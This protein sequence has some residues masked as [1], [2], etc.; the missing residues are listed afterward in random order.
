MSRLAQA[1][2]IVGCICVV[3]VAAMVQHLV[4]LETGIQPRRLIVPL[5]VGASFGILIVALVK[6]RAAQ[7]QSLA[8]LAAQRAEIAALNLR[9]S[10]TVRSQG[11]E[12]KTAERRLIEA[13]RLGAV[14]LLAGGVAHD[15]NNL[16]TV[17]LSGAAFLGE[18]AEG[19]EKEVVE[20]MLSAGERGATLTTQLL[21]LARPPRQSS[22]VRCLNRS[23]EELESL[24]RRLLG[25][26]IRLEVNRCAG[27]L[28][29]PVGRASL[30]QVLV[31]LVVNA[32]DAMP[33]GGTFTIATERG[34]RSAVLR[35]RDTGAGMSPEVQARIFQPFF[36]TKGEGRG[37]GLGLAVVMD[38][39]QRAGG[40]ISVDSKPGQGTTF[41][42]SFPLADVDEAEATPPASTREAL[43]ALVFADEEPGL[44]LVTGS[45]MEQQGYE[46]KACAG[47]AEALAALEAVLQSGRV[48]ALVTDI[49][50]ADGDGHTLVHEARLRAPRLPVVMTSSFGLA[51]VEG[52]G[53]VL[54]KPYT[55][56]RLM[57]ALDKAIRLARQ[58]VSPAARS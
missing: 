26:S 33:G 7:R 14:G 6:A 19:E 2:T 48:V 40:D 17:V 4:V 3:L 36:T 54:A 5:V 53:V 22:E 13:D 31:N 30:E 37:T 1:L 20:S 12:L 24:S 41:V 57:E 43:V 16:L 56:A 46:V 27:S 45:A 21:A 58:E 32:R 8:S 55:P 47:Q 23:V 49:L 10:E 38:A 50:L 11:N 42:L 29:V 34:E 39:I 18:T 25:S 15:F 9:L 35:V 44:R 28:S 51:E 52:A